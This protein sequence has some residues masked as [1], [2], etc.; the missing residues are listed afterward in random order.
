MPTI[1]LLVCVNILD[2]IYVQLCCDIT[3]NECNKGIYY[4]IIFYLQFTI[5]LFFHVSIIIYAIV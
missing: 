3:S 1:V 2:K 4:K 5:L